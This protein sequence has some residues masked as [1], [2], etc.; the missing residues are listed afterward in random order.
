MNRE[1]ALVMVL[2][3]LAGAGVTMLGWVMISKAI[4]AQLAEGGVRMLEQGG[5]SLQTTM[6]QTLQREVPPLVQ[7]AVQTKLNE[8]GLDPTTG[9]RI[10]AVL[11]AADR[12]GLIGLRGYR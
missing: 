5:R 4:D 1:T 8:A 11:E 9:R 6:V 7:A 2:G 3:G 12:T 10:A